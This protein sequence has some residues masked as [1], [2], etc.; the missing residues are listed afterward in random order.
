[1]TGIP[2][3]APDDDPPGP[4][5]ETG[6]LAI[7]ADLHGPW[8]TLALGGTLDWLTASSLDGRITAVTAQHTP[9]WLALDLSAL[10]FC[11]TSGLNILIRAYKGVI[12]ANGRFLLLSPSSRVAQL[13]EI[14]GLDRHLTITDVLPD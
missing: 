13:L 2:T 9:P 7:T 3:A 8:V 11:D 12:A 10:T 5:D 14:T 6:P 1:M 4:D